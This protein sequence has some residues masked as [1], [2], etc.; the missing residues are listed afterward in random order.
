M[1]SI[2]NKLASAEDSSTQKV[3]AAQLTSGST[4]ES[5]TATVASERVLSPASPGNVSKDSSKKPAAFN[6]GGLPADLRNCYSVRTIEA[7]NQFSKYT[8][9]TPTDALDLRCEFDLPRFKNIKDKRPLSN[10]E[11]HQN[12][13][14]FQRQRDY[15]TPSNPGK[16]ANL[17][18]SII[19]LTIHDLKVKKA[20][21]ERK[22]KE[23]R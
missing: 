2:L 22:E 13:L 17:R 10:H 19:N 12:F 11:D 8:R 15:T 1:G 23:Q 3:K 21:Q 20:S 5:K 14:W 9:Y 6:S 18:T 4:A 16:E 7:L